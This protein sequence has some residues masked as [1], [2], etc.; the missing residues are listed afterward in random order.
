MYIYD[1]GKLGLHASTPSYEPLA[2]D[3][4][5]KDAP[6]SSR[7]TAYG[8]ALGQVPEDVDRAIIIIAGSAGRGMSVLPECNDTRRGGPC[9]P[10]Q[11]S[12]GLCA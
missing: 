8:V 9:C 1:G 11:A 12:N 4:A 6:Q 10:I 2:Q 7:I 5:Q 3:F